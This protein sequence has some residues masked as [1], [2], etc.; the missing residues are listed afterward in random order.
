MNL[1][2]ELT[3]LFKPENQVLNMHTECCDQKMKLTDTFGHYENRTYDHPG[4]F[5]EDH[6]LYRCQICG[7]EI[8][9]NK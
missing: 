9:I 4:D 8:K 6:E 7:E 2:D 5:V 1:L 3:M